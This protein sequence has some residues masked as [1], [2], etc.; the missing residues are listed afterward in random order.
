M[1]AGDYIVG[2]I[3]CWLIADVG[4]GRMVGVVGWHAD[5]ENFHW[6]WTVIG[7]TLLAVGIYKLLTPRV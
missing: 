2:G 5:A 1:R 3:L 4:A 7:T 6:Y